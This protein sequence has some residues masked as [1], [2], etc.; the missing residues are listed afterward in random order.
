MLQITI[1]KRAAFIALVAVLLV[2]P[3]A[4]FAGS[5]SDDVDD[6]S[7]HIEG[8]TYWKDSGVSVG[9]GANNNFCPD[10]SVARAQMGTFMYRLSGNDPATDPSVNAATL[11]GGDALAYTPQ[12]DGISCDA[13]DRAAVAVIA[14]VIVTELV[15]DVPADGYIQA[16]YTVAGTATVVGSNVFQAWITLEGDDGCGWFFFPTDDI[17][18]SYSHQE[19]L[20]GD[21]FA[22]A[23]GS[24][25][26]AVTA[27]THTVSFCVV[28]VSD[29][30]TVSSA[31]VN[32]AWSAAGSSS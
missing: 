17:G 26:A 28:S 4:A 11:D 7:T 22:S 21:D 31:G 32:T 16:S 8:I 10:D 3:V 2:I 27:G 6:G 13:A 30:W 23:S 25:V 15:I 19:M 24:A 1:S 9:C 5:V 20:T 18:G 14:P 29:A 12:I